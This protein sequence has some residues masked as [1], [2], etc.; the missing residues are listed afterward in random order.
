MIYPPAMQPQ[1]RMMAYRR[2]WSHQVC[3]HKASEGSDGNAR[4]TFILALTLEEFVISALI[5]EQDW[6]ASQVVGLQKQTRQPTL[7]DN[8]LLEPEDKTGFSD[9]KDRVAMLRQSG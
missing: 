2:Q 8:R 1:T 3:R 4:S 5:P 7:K 9:P 6:S